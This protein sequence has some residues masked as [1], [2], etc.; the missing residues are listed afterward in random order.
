M[1]NWLLSCLPKDGFPPRLKSD[2]LKE[3]I[4][5]MGIILLVL[6][7]A[8]YRIFIGPTGETNLNIVIGLV[9][10]L[11]IWAFFKGF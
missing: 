3:K 1:L 7:V 4:G 5:C 2:L 10:I 6:G 8:L 9:V 11:Y